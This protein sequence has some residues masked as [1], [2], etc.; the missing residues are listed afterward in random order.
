[1]RR[2]WPRLSNTRFSDRPISDPLAAGNSSAQSTLYRRVV[3]KL[4]NTFLGKF[5]EKHRGLVHE[6]NN[7]IGTDTSQLGLAVPTE[8]TGHAQGRRFSFKRLF[9]VRRDGQTLPRF[10][11]QPQSQSQ[12][13]PESQ[14]QPHP[15]SPDIQEQPSPDPRAAPEPLSHTIDGLSRVSAAS[16]PGTSLTGSE[17]D[18]PEATRSIH[19]IRSIGQGDSS[20]SHSLRV[21][22]GELLENVPEAPENEPA[23]PADEVSQTGVTSN[24]SPSIRR[25]DFAYDSTPDSPTPSFQVSLQASSSILSFHTAQVEPPTRPVS[26]ATMFPELTRFDSPQSI[27]PRRRLAS[28]F[29]RPSSLRDSMVIASIE[30]VADSIH[31]HGHTNGD[32]PPLPLKSSPLTNSA[33]TSAAAPSRKILII[34]SPYNRDER[35]TATMFSARTLDGVNEDKRQLQEAFEQRNYLVDT[36][37]NN[38][39][40]RDQVLAKVANF[41]GDAERGDVRAVAFTGHAFC[42]ADGTV[43]LVPPFCPDQTAAIPRDE[44]DKNIQENSKPGAIIFSIMAHCF[45]GQFMKQD[46]EYPNWEQVVSDSDPDAKAEQ[47]IYVT[48]SASS[49]EQAAFQSSVERDNPRF[50]SDHFVYSLVRAMRD[51]KAQSWRDFFTTFENYFSKARSCASLAAKEGQDEH[52]RVAPVEAWRANNEQVPSFSASAR[53]PL[54]G[55]F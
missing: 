27:A 44:W 30:S 8:A 13:Q 54:E 34:G 51:S 20:S 11:L 23:N 32:T 15:Q 3:S 18:R 53:V 33:T 7:A 40:T 35:R 42:A 25:R 36:M 52:G 17:H 12:P 24:V 9:F 6:S 41:V 14:L 2:L 43:M 50:V 38:V 1:M 22:Q 39:F 55:V 26:L 49:G 19:S 5:I 46:L 31:K 28:S 45:S 4:R 21:R 29:G 47:A 16:S 10:N 37:V 48:F